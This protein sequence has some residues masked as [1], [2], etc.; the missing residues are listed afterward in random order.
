MGKLDHSLRQLG[1]GSGGQC[2]FNLIAGYQHRPKAPASCPPDVGG[3]KAVFRS[4]QP[5]HRAMLSVG[6]HGDNDC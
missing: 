3:L 1:F 6:T 2:S 4:H 5:H